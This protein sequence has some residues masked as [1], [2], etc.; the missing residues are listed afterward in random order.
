[1]KFAAEI[2]EGID[3]EIRQL[4][5]TKHEGIIVTPV[6]TDSSSEEGVALLTAR[7]LG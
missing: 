4:V 6:D 3:I 7:K 1:M 2:L 5:N